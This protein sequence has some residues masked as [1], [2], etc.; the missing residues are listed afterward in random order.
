ME[1]K[2]VAEARNMTGLRLVLTA[3]VPAP[4]SESAKALLKI[5]GIPYIPVLQKAAAPNEELVDWT[6]HRNAPTV[7]FEDEPPRITWLD[8]VNL[9]ERLQPT[10]S[11]VPQNME[12][13]ILMTGLM[14][15]LAGEGGMLWSTRQLM[16]RAMA[17]A[18]G[19]DAVAGNPM[20]RNYR[21][22]TEDTASASGKAIK[23]LQRLE[24]QLE[25]QAAAGSR[26]FI[27]DCLSV[28]D[29]YWACFSQTL[30]P[31]P[32]EV[33]PMPDSLRTMWESGADAL[34]KDG[35]TPH[36]RLFEHRDYIY[37]EHIGL[38]LDF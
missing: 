36:D 17:E 3:G 30:N 10:P 25:H 13:R 33:N 9:V 23:I 2:T 27:A 19:E 34:A 26:Y 31:L 14:N 12:D 38:P 1:Y 7:M 5:K 6:G 29:V 18:V 28:L 16:F 20:F 37:H 35:Y 15:E 4:W 11:L 8:I 32:K 24:L 22:S 21:Y